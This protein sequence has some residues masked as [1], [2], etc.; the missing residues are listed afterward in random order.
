MVYEGL[1]VYSNVGLLAI[2]VAL[3][4]VF[5]MHAWPKLSNAAA[6]AKGMKWGSW[7]VMLLGLWESVGALS[8]L[9]GV[10][11]QIGAIMLGIVMLGALHHKIFKWKMPFASMS[12]TGWEFDLM[13]LASS[14]AV[15]LVGSGTI[16]LLP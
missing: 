10:Y 12:S 4:A 15:A 9:L 16:A 14:I 13:L 1:I 11:P 6:M 2:R 8:V 5:L 7:Q 3:G